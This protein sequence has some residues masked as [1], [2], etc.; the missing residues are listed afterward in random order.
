MN[1]DLPSS[2][3]V[4]QLASYIFFPHTGGCSEPLRSKKRP[5][6]TTE[7]SGPAFG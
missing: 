5:Y 6:S 1:V 3:F 4:I 7:E 2:L